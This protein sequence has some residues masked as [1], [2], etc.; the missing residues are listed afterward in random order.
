MRKIPHFESL[1]SRSPEFP[2]KYTAMKRILLIDDEDELRS[3]LRMSLE[4]MGYAVTEARNG[5][6]AMKLFKK[7][8]ADLVLTDLIMPE[9][10]GLETIRQLRRRNPE[11]KIIAM[12]GGGRS[13]A[14]DNLKMA[15]SFGATLA[16]AKP[17]SFDALAKAIAGLLAEPKPDHS[18]PVFDP[19]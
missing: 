11:L 1:T 14:R 12:S 16:F 2:S 5:A 8:P 10:E 6:E 13:D 17:F 15:R 7:A 18:D 4:K 19:E 9:K 3:I